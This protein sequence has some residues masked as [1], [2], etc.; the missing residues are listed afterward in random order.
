MIKYND[1]GEGGIGVRR[2]MNAEKRKL[3]DAQGNKQKKIMN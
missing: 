1:K 2:E 3:G